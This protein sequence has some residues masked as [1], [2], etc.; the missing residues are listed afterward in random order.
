MGK[1]AGIKGGRLSEGMMLMELDR[2]QEA[3]DTDLWVLT[4]LGFLLVKTVLER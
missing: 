3:S 2:A 4:S 1:G